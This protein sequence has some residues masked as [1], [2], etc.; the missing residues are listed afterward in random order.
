LTV[1]SAWKR[2]YCNISFKSYIVPKCRTVIEV[3]VHN[4]GLLKYV[5]EKLLWFI[6]IFLELREDP[7]RISEHFLFYFLVP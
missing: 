6:F 4:L 3:K 2:N 1:R 5:F 7:F